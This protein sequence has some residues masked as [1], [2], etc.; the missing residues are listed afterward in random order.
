M[1]KAII[2][3]GF[4]IFGLG[5]ST[6]SAILASPQGTNNTHPS[7]K[8]NKKFIRLMKMLTGDVT[9]VTA[10]G[11]GTVKVLP[12]GSSINVSV[13]VL[14]KTH[15]AA[16]ESLLR[17]AGNITSHFKG[18]PYLKS[19]Q[20]GF[21]GIMPH[22]IYKDM[23][24]VKDGY[25]GTENLI[26]NVS[27]NKNTNTALLFLLKQKYAMINSVTPVFNHLKKYKLMAVKLA[28]LEALSKAKVI[29]NSLKI[30]SFKVRKVEVRNVPP[31]FPMPRFM[32]L[33]AA[34]VGT[35][36]S[37]SHVYF[38]KKGKVASEVFIKLIPNN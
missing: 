24:W 30:K 9:S 33:K 1:K 7:Y 17:N 8:R 18:L 31:V 23:K 16:Y 14:E 20:T 34:S 3:F 19:M 12:S 35:G 25:E 36:T 37:G 6:P 10:V 5:L 26:V 4:I 2:L 21:V 13:E 27:G 29:F 28:Y 15:D 32:A 22:K 38:Y 11:T